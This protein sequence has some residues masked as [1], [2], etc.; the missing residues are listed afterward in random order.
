M[1]NS[2]A[3][4]IDGVRH[5][6]R[7]GIS[8]AAALLAARDDPAFRRTMKRREPRGIFCGMGVCFDCLVT[9]DDRANI[10]ACMTAVADGM[11]IVTE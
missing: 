11:R 4:F 2:V 10:R 3:I 7:P 9:V 1:K 6:A 8:V 5:E